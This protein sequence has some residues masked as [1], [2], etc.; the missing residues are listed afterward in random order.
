LQTVGTKQHIQS[1]LRDTPIRFK[2]I[3]IAGKIVPFTAENLPEFHTLAPTEARHNI[4]E[5]YFLIHI[6]QFT[7]K[8]E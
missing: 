1:R 4:Y 6:A 5:E 3:N 2:S 7:A 8:S